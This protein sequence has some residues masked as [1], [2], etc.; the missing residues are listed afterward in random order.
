M[1][2]Y[3]FLMENVDD[4]VCEKLA[5]AMSAETKEDSGKEIEAILNCRAWKTTRKCTWLCE[6]D[7]YFYIDEHQHAAAEWL[8]H[9]GAQYRASRTI[10]SGKNTVRTTLRCFSVTAA[11]ALM[12]SLLSKNYRNWVPKGKHQDTILTRD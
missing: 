7:Y 5:A 1:F 4:Y 12:T 11:A 3:H 10:I 2:K 6:L 9:H 8:L